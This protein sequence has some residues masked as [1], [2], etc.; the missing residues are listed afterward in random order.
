MCA[1]STQ[2][3]TDL[4]ALL[5]TYSDMQK[6]QLFGSVLRVAF[7]DAGEFSLL[8]SS[9]D[10][11]GPDGCLSLTPDNAGLIES[12]KIVSTIIQPW[13]QRHCALGISR[14][15]FWTLLAK[16]VTERSAALGGAT[17]SVAFYFGRKDALVCDAGAGRLPSA[18]ATSA[19]ATQASLLA[20]M[21][22]TTSDVV[23]L[24]GAHSVGH[25]HPTHSGFGSPSLNASLLESNAWDQTPH[26]LDN[27]YFV[28]LVTHPWNVVPSTTSTKQFYADLGSKGHLMLNP[29]M[30]LAFQIG[31]NVPPLQA[32]AVIQGKCGGAGNK[33]ARTASTQALIDSYIASNSAFVS[34][35]AAAMTK[36]SNVGYSYGTV[37]SGKLGSLSPMTC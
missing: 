2:I 32:G 7:H 4:D 17:V 31:A 36:M 6:A 30:A 20:G 37:T 16:A 15:D 19:S 33:C 12:T 3:Y 21:G 1:L 18:S 25:A 11:L 23:T 14:G 34:A 10:K 8:T 9:T 35:F 26:I 13:W 24:L 29:D 28:R 27:Q 5:K 22:L